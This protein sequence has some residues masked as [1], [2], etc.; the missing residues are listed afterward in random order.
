MLTDLRAR[1]RHLASSAASVH[2]QL[3]VAFR[4]PSSQADP[5][6]KVVRRP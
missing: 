3:D 5:V 2:A 4:E 1:R 6:E